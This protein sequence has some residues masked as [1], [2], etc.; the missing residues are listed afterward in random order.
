MLRIARILF[1]V[2]FSDRCALIGGRVKALAEHFQ[3]GVVLLYTLEPLPAHVAA[4]DMTPLIPETTAALKEG[5]RAELERFL[6]KE[7]S[8]LAVR[9]VLAEGFAAEAIVQHAHALQA[10]LILMPTRGLGAFRR[11]I[12]GS[13]TAKVLHDANCPVWTGVHHEQA[14]HV[15]SELRHV[16]CAVDLGPQSVTALAWA[17]GFASQWQSKLT[18]L[19]VAPALEPAPGQYFSPDWRIP[20]MSWSREELQKIRDSVGAD[21][22]IHVET[23]EAAKTVVATAATLKAD[24]LVIGRSPHDG[25]VG[26][27]RANA[28][29]II[30]QS[31]C[32]VVSL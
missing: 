10:D 31:P 27:L 22:D 18:L 16:V 1:P 5:A 7:F 20:I 17:S 25:L 8:H 14:P 11:Y 26:R 21:C 6:K 3:A 19:H 15:W 28:Y 29:A 4:L 2:D 12:I 30:T 13:V 23:G 32:P 24:L 9:R